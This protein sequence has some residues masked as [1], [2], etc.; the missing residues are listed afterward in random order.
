MP[1]TTLY[2]TSDTTFK[3]SPKQASELGEDDKYY[4]PKEGSFKVSAIA[5]EAEHIK[6]TLGKDEDGNQRFIKGRNTWYVYNRHASVKGLESGLVGAIAPADI[7]PQF[8]SIASTFIRSFEG[9]ELNQYICPA[10]ISTI[11]YG[12]TALTDSSLIPAGLTITANEAIQLFDHDSRR[13]CKALRSLLKVPLTGKQIAA[14]SSF[15]YNTGESALAEST[16]LKTI[17]GKRPTEEIATQFMRWTNDGLAGLVR[18]RAAEV[19]LWKGL[20]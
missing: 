14:L 17:N 10:G 18:R 16:L 2:I 8:N 12:S 13:F 3:A 7:Y 20:E 5:N 19:D 4:A 9:L 6:F 11:G 1:E 15:I